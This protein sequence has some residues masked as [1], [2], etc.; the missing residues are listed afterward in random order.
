[1]KICHVCNFECEDEAELCPI[2]GADLTVETEESKEENEEILLK[3]PVLLASV[4]DIVSAEILK[5]I[6]ISNKIPFT[7]AELQE[8]A[9]RVVF[10]GGFALNDIYVDSC[11][12][13]V[14]EKLYNE[15][16]ENKP[17]F[18]G[19]FFEEEEI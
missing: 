10:G 3:N 11:D 8:N 12:F 4:E 16:L 14:A 15:F 1:M 7:T 9:M 2:C 17:E 19:E 6:L 13:E 18:D 5:D